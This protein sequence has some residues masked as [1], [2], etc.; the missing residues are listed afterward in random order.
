MP[1]VVTEPSDALSLS[2]GRSAG[3]SWRGYA[4]AYAGKVKPKVLSV[5]AVFVTALI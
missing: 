1:T 4:N 3:N 5:F 2:K